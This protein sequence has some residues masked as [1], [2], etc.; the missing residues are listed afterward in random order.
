VV[1]NTED[2][3]E[4][5]AEDTKKIAAYGR[6]FVNISEPIFVYKSYNPAGPEFSGL[7]LSSIRS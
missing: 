3:K 6:I 4:D 5:H 7:D 2:T 1:P